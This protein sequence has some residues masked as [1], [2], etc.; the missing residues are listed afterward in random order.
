MYSLVSLSIGKKFHKKFLFFYEIP[1]ITSM[2]IKMDDE[3][4]NL[5]VLEYM[6]VT[7]SKYGR[8]NNATAINGINLTL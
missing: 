1:M 8:I 5:D 7:D 3:V 6:I 4:V 2:K